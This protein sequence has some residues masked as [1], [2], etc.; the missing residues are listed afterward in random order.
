MALCQQTKT[1][2]RIPLAGPCL[3]Y[4]PCGEKLSPHK[5]SG[6]QPLP[7]AG[8]RRRRQ[9]CLRGSRKARL[10]SWPHRYHD[11]APFEP[12]AICGPS[13]KA[14]GQIGPPCPHSVDTRLGGPC[15]NPPDMFLPG[16]PSAWTI[17][18][19]PLQKV[20]GLPIVYRNRQ[21]CRPSLQNRY[22]SADN[23][24]TAASFT[25]RSRVQPPV[26]TS[27][28]SRP[29]TV[30]ISGGCAIIEK[31]NQYG[32]LLWKKFLWRYVSSRRQ[33]TAFGASTEPV[34]T[35]AVAAAAA[36][37]AMPKIPRNAADHWRASYAPG[38]S[39]TW[40]RCLAACYR[41]AIAPLRRFPAFCVHRP[42]PFV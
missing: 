33:F 25:C 24:L 41:A 11:V 5:A 16:N 14:A 32:V 31:E 2:Q 18:D 1:G 6:K 15:T 28:L 42:L 9:T 4:G 21:P 8:K 29:T 37:D 13:G 3:W 40:D 35:V 34:G 38:Q 26:P 7:S 36:K 10:R 39:R 19:S 30:D 27:T 23:V 22:G 17:C 20:V 12:T